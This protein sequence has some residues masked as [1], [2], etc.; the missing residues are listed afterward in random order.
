M[1]WVY[2]ATHSLLTGTGLQQ[3]VGPYA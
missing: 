1:V 2:E 3:C